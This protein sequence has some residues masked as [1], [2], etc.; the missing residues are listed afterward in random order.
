MFRHS[1]PHPHVHIVR[2]HAFRAVRRVTV[3]TAF[4]LMGIAALLRSQGVITQQELWL[5]LPGAVALSGLVRMV[6]FPGAAS[7]VGGLV[8]LAIAAYLVVVIEHIGGWTLAATWPVLLIAVG[9]GMVAHALLG[10][11]WHEEPN[12]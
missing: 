6:A 3:G 10:Q 5:V 7:L 12:W 1:R 4:I 9:T 11:R 8:R 2:W